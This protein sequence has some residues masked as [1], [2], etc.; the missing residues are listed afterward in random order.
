MSIFTQIVFE[1]G[2]LIEIDNVKAQVKTL[3]TMDQYLHHRLSAVSELT[4]KLQ[5]LEETIADTV[6][7]K[8][9]KKHITYS[10]YD[11][12][13]FILH[14]LTKA[15][16]KIASV[17]RKYNIN[18]RTGQCWWNQYKNDPDSF[19]L[20]KPRDKNPSTNVDQAL[21]QLTANFEGL[22]IGKL[23]VYDFIRKDM[24]FTFK[25]AELHSQKRNDKSAIQERYEWACKI[26]NSD[27]DF[28][29]NCVFI[30]ES[31][32]YINMNRGEA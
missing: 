11:T 26:A 3:V 25:R 28:L 13:N 9:K 10:D 24:G 8:K 31:G 20:T 7:V 4:N 21:D 22:K 23:A 5:I 6:L 19:F 27:I 29:K 2:E 1:D 30:D 14:M 15:P 16:K 12:M 18:E 17:A 32:F